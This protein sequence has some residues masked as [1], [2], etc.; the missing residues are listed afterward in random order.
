MMRYLGR[1][2]P[3]GGLVAAAVVAFSATPAGATI[4]C[5]PGHTPPPGGGT[6]PYCKNVPP[7]AVTRPATNVSANSAKLNGRVGAGVAGGDPTKYFFQYGTS[8]AYGSQTP[9][10]ILGACQAGVSPPSPYCTTPDIHPVSAVV[11]GLAPCTTYHFMVVAKNA[12]GR[13]KGADATFRTRFATAITNFDSPPTVRRGQRFTVKITLGA[14]ARLTIFISRHCR[15]VTL[16]R[17]GLQPA[18]TFTARITAPNRSG[19][20]TLGVVAKGSCGQE[21]VTNRLQVT[22]NGNGHHHHHHHHN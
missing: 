15:V 14:P 5:Q 10:A 13:T 16:I 18:G 17:T 2:A 22:G 1:L 9:T 4:V 20:Y 3:L 8:T 21:I 12:D 6:G 11:R 7:R 19:R